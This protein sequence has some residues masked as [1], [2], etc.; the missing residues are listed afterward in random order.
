M[1]AR[2]CTAGVRMRA[3]AVCA[4]AGSTHTRAP[5]PRSARERSELRTLICIYGSIDRTY[6][7]R[8]APN[9]IIYS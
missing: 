4:R 2:R 7:V 5:F 3:D 8:V 6:C 1:F 9:L